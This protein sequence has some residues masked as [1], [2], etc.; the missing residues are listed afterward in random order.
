VLLLDIHGQ[1]A[2]ND[3][4]LIGTRNGE[5]ANLQY[6]EA[7]SEGFLWHLRQTL[8]QTI[9]PGRGQRELEGYTGGYTVH[10]HCGLAVDAVQ[11]EFGSS[12]RRSATERAK[13]AEKV[14]QAILHYLQ[15]LIPFFAS[16]NDRS[17]PTWAT[18]EQKARITALQ[19]LGITTPRQLVDALNQGILNP[20]LEL[21]AEEP[22][23]DAVISCILKRSVFLETQS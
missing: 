23:S 18:K 1:C 6:L 3:H 8:G 13:I 10:R 15:P 5:T 16:I 21:S 9:L 20:K 7:E 22:L 19:K 11:L 14:S 17:Q 2:F 12:W 4:V